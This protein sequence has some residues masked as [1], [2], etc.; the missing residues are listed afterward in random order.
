MIRGKGV[1]FLLQA[2]A[3]IKDKAWGC[4]IAGEGSHLDTCKAL[5]EELGLSDRVTFAGRLNREKLDAEYQQARLGV[6]PSV[7]PE[8]MGMVGLEFMW[9]SLPVVAFDAGG[10]SHWLKDG[11]TG[12]LAEPKDTQ[13]FA[14]NIANLLDDQPLAEKMGRHARSVAEE[15]YRHDHYIDHLLNILTDATAAKAL[16]PELEEIPLLKISTT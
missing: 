3:L 6:V 2:L 7:W 5:A 10:I 16:R 11:E 9:A 13:A 12:Y 15:N 8:P 4:T 1:D 14:D